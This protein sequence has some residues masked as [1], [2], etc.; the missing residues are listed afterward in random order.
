M[1]INQNQTFHYT[2]RITSKR[3]TSLRCSSPRHSAKVNTVT[4]VD[5]EAVANRLQRWV[6][7]GRSRIWT[8]GTRVRLYAPAHEVHPL[9]V[10]LIM[11]SRIL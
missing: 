7:F 6:R 4:C 10:R 3:V 5:V 11:V 1:L 9:T 8:L 2:H